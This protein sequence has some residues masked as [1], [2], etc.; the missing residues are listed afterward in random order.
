VH[1]EADDEAHEP[2]EPS[3]RPPTIQSGLC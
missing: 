3:T 2:H 1:E